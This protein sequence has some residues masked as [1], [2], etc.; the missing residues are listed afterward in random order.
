M[1]REW[2]RYFI[3]MA[4]VLCSILMGVVFTVLPFFI[5]EPTVAGNPIV[6]GFMF[7]LGLFG[8]LNLPIW[9]DY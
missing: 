8:T 9:Y 1:N 5:V 3:T 7:S 4:A 6:F 2:K